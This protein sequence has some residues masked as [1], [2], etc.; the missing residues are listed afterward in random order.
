MS[1]TVSSRF[2]MCLDTK[3][4][5][6]IIS[7]HDRDGKDRAFIRRYLLWAV[8]IEVWTGLRRKK[9]DASNIHDGGGI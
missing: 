9:V 8:R 1:I 6:G 5:L 3:T 7:L 2:G 4:M